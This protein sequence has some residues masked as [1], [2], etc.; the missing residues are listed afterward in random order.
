MT[1]VLSFSV[2]ITGT[3]P[4]SIKCVI[5]DANC[6]R[7]HRWSPHCSSS[8]TTSLGKAVRASSTALLN[9]APLLN[10]SIACW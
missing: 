7:V 8:L 1:I 6:F 2:L 4:A 3:Y 10:A 5:A 9:T